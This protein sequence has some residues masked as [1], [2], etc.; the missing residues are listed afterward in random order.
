[1]SRISTGQNGEAIARKYLEKNGYRIL[2]A[3][4]RSKNAELDLI[5]RKGREIVFVE[6]RAKSTDA[7][8]T[9]AESVTRH[10]QRKLISAAQSYLAENKIDGDWRID[11]I[12]IQFTGNTHQ[13]EHIP[14]AVSL[15]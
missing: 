3:N 12:G 15:E 2:A 14:Y 8:G 6:V 10:K 13:L 11:F 1:M 9:P 4:W 5:A 7:F